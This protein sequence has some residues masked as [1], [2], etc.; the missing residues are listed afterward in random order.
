MGETLGSGLDVSEKGHFPVGLPT[1]TK[2]NS[3]ADHDLILLREG[4]WPA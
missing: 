4:D 1:L 2:K 3:S